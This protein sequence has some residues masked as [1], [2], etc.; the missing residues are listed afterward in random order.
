M[1]K[2]HC[3]VRLLVLLICF[4]LVWPVLPKIEEGAEAAQRRSSKSKKRA[5][6]KKSS[7]KRASGRRAR[8]SRRS[9]RA[10]TPVVRRKGFDEMIGSN[11]GTLD[12]TDEEVA[13]AQIE[14]FKL[15]AYVK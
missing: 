11:P 2:Y 6:A 13:G 10:S 4:G 7:G 3:L 9:R 5:R 14:E 12:G 8:R 15:R 1:K